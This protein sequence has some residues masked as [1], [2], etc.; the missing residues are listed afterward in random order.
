MAGDCGVSVENSWLSARGSALK[1]FDRAGKLYLRGMLPP[2]T[3]DRSQYPNQYAAPKRQ[4]R[5]ST[6]LSVDPANVKVVSGIAMQITAKL[7]AKT[8]DWLEIPGIIQNTWQKSQQIPDDVAALGQFAEDKSLL[9]PTPTIFHAPDSLGAL[10][11]AKG[12]GVQLSLSDY[13]DVVESIKRQKLHAGRVLEDTWHR[14]YYVPYSKYIS[15]VISSGRTISTQSISDFLQSIE[16]GS[17]KRKRYYTT[18]HKFI[19]SS[20]LSRDF[21]DASGITVDFCTL[22]G[23]YTLPILEPESLPSDDEFLVGLDKVNFYDS[24]W[25]DVYKYLLLFGLRN[26]ELLD[27]DLSNYPNA[28][29]R[30]S[31]TRK[32]RYV[33]PFNPHWVDELKLSRDV[34]LPQIN[35]KSRYGF[36]NAV[37]TL[38]RK[39]KL[40]YRP[41]MLRHRWARNTA[42]LGYDTTLAAQMMGHSLQIHC[43]VYMKFV[44]LDSYLKAMQNITQPV[45]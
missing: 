22:S 33:L 16:P 26:T 3:F 8:F 18:F 23:T 42:E 7:Q 28:F 17:R 27:F 11:K 4:A 13:W 10:G 41:L 43:R 24:Q 9:S 6:K 2:K 39:A 31:K 25:V 5:I 30:K 19:E 12:R 1:I 32:Q 34:R 37:T 29:V 35:R 40:D 44:G 36:S 20:G 15:W 45:Q 14:E 21:V 38:F